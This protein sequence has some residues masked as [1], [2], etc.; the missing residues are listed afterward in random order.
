MKIIRE[1]WYDVRQIEC[2]DGL[3]DVT[4]GDAG[5][6][7]NNEFKSQWSLNAFRKWCRIDSGQWF[8]C[9]LSNEQIGKLTKQQILNNE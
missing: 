6:N 4:S 3:V 2:L 8:W 1:K 9:K 5:S 7:P